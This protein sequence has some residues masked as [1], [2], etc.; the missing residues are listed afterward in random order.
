[1]PSHEAM[2]A[3]HVFASH[4]FVQCTLACNAL[5]LVCSQSTLCSS[6]SSPSLASLL[7]K[8]TDPHIRLI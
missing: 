7:S 3:C 5:A 1:M 2:L 6:I 4:S 8:K